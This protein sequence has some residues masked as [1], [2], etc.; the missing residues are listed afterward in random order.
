MS[1]FRDYDDLTWF[2]TILGAHGI[3]GAVK[4]K[5]FTETP[6]Y[7]LSVKSFLI[8]NDGQLRNLNVSRIVPSKKG[9]IIHFKEIDCREDAEKRKGCRLLL[10]DKQL[11][12]LEAGEYFVYQLIGCRVEDQNGIFLG[13]VTNFFETGANNVF[14]VSGGRKEFMIPD[15]PHVVLEMDLEKKR[16]V[17]DPI[18]GLIQY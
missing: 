9:W 18:P 1:E 14:E 15:V 2:A 13:K 3:K 11:K 12:P 7:Y 6:E 4:V 16:L 5:F 8:E 10:P 17:I